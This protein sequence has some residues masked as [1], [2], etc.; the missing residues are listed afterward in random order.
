MAVTDTHAEPD[1]GVPAVPTRSRLPK[2]I[3]SALWFLGILT[4]LLVVWELYIALGKATDGTWPFLSS[5]LP[6]DPNNGAMP[7]VWDIVDEL[8]TARRAGDDILL[9]FLL[10]EA[11]FTFREALIGFVAGSSF[12]FAL[13]VV[14]ARYR[15]L[16]RGLM[17]YVI[18]SQTVPLLAIAP[19]IVIWSGRL[20]WPLWIPPAIIA[21]Y[22]SFFPVTINTLRGLRSPEPTSLELMRS[23][24]AKPR[25]V[26]W[27]VQVPSAL[28]YIFTA[29]KVA[30]T[31]SV[32]GALVGELPSSLNQGLGRALL[33][34]M[35][36]F[37]SGPEK[38]YAAILVS[39]LLG[40]VFVTLVALAERAALPSARRIQ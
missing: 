23:Y 38:L 3:R 28:P 1:V 20:G 6:V 40:I 14:F 4:F 27:K 29:L 9:L 2:P 24:A 15:L 8:F 30:A 34:F 21:A 17:P 39:A 36:S 7:H 35:Y 13:A 22:L 16:E 12:G 19:M 32:I 37:I 11:L 26:L 31:A 10:K 18:A 25:E 5:E 33:S